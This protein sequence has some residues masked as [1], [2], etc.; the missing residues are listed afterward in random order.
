VR[1][2]VIIYFLPG[3]VQCRRA[4]LFLVRNRIPFTE[5]NVLTHPNVLDPRWLGCARILPLI[6]VGPRTI[7]GWNQ[8]QF[9]AALRCHACRHEGKAPPPLRRQP[10]RVRHVHPKPLGVPDML[11]GP[12]PNGGASVHASREHR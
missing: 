1:S 11:A 9:L 7:Q 2:R 5:V 6:T 12:E 4:R 8:R 3:C 10:V